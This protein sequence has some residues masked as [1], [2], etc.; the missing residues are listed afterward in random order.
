MPEFRFLCPHCPVQLRLRDRQLIGHLIQCPDCSGEVAIVDDGNGDPTGAVPSLV[1]TPATPP[2]LTKKKKK[3]RKKSV[4]APESNTPSIWKSVAV[5]LGNPVTIAWLVAGVFTTLFIVSI[6]SDN[7]QQAT[8]SEETD[9]EKV[10]QQTPEKPEQK[11]ETIPTPPV[12]LDPEKLLK[13]RLAWLGSE[14]LAQEKANQHFPGGAMYVDGIPVDDRFSWQADIVARNNPDMKP[15]FHP[16]ISWKATENDRFI[17]RSQPELL[18]PLLIKQV[19]QRGYPTTHFVG[20]AGL[21]HDG[22]LLDVTHPRAGVFGMNRKT[23]Q[24]DITDGLSQTMMIAGV[25]ENLGSWAGSGPGTIRPFTQAPYVN[26]PDGFGT[27][28]P[29]RML[30]VMADGSVKPVSRDIAPHVFRRMVTIA[31]GVS[32]DAPETENPTPK[33]PVTEEPDNP[34]VVAETP[35]EKPEV[36]ELKPAPVVEKLPPIDIAGR[37]DQKLFSYRLTQPRSVQSLLDELE[38]MVAVRFVLAE[39]VPPALL[40][41]EITFSLKEATVGDLMR[42]VMNKAELEYDIRE[43]DIFLRARGEA[44]NTESEPTDDL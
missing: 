8:A 37:L 10:A 17:R 32:P 34:P 12:R 44:V 21:G 22:P 16:Q 14:L 25:Q 19:G 39:T 18:N 3:K 7:S 20:V 31:E 1:S 5:F 27:G 42:V 40:N 41:R 35:E 36:P 13:K 26:G 29:D 2:T 30:V 4:P 11:K 43:R 23:R 28:M 24:T 9:S 6:W 38:E 33:E 15:H